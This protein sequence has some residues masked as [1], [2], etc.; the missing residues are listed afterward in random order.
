MIRL[1]AAVVRVIATTSPSTLAEIDR[2]GT[3]VELAGLDLREIE[4]VVDELQQVAA[5]RQDVAEELLVLRRR[6]ID[7]AVVQ[8]LGE[9]DDR[10]ERRAQLV[11]HVREELALEPVRFLDA[12]VLQLELDR[13]PANLLDAAPLAQV[14]D[15]DAQQLM[16]RRRQQRERTRSGT[17]SPCASTA[18]PLEH[19]GLVPR[20]ARSRYS[21]RDLA[22][23]PAVGLALGD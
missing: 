21:R 15:A 7:L 11:R 12:A 2:L 1:L 20:I 3:E 13:A 5:A 8:Q 17:A 18:R 4:H 6:R 23:Q 10:V 14:D 9:A 22:R 16:P 19:D